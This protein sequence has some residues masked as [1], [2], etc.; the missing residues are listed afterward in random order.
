FEAFMDNSHAVAFMKDH[1]GR[2][3]YM[4]RRLIETFP[5]IADSW[6]GKRD[7]ELWPESAAQFLQHD[8][9]V[10]AAG[11]SVQAIQQMQSSTGETTHWQVLKF[12][13]LDVSGHAFI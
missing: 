2:Y 1:Q 4:N 5:H 11:A 10:L 6:F 8:S 13:F 9:D 12:P 3:V 7:M